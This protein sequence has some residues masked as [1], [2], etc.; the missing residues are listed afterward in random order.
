[1]RNDVRHLP[2]DVDRAHV[3]DAF[4][5]EAG[6]ER[7]GRDAVLAGA[8]LGDDA[9]L[10]HAARQHDLAG[11]VV[12]LVRAGVVQLLALQVDLRA[13]E[14]LG[15]ALGEIE[16]ARP[17]DVM[18]QMAVHLGLEGRVGLGALVFRLELQDVRHQGLGDEAAAEDAEHAA[19]VRAGPEG[20]RFWCAVM[21]LLVSC[22][23][24]ESGARGRDESRDLSRH[25]SRRAG[26]RRPTRRPPPRGPSSAIAPGDVLRRQ[27]TGQHD[28]QSRRSSADEERPVEGDAVAAGQRGAARRLRVEQHAIGPPR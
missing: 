1:M 14:M 7:R 15:Q 18:R 27:T 2:L 21:R 4:E 6:A 19:L 28:G 10:A 25:P 24:R 16:R 5:A 8:R 26:S 22:R 12:H 3:D 13:A 9:L 23:G 20:V 17:A 11:D